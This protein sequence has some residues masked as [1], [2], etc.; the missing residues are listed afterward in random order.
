VLLTCDHASNAVPRALGGLGLGEAALSDHIGWDIG[1]AAVT[2]PLARVLDAPAI[3]SGYSRLVVDCHRD[4]GDPTS[5]PAVSDGVSIPGNRDLSPEARAARI[6]ACFAP[7]HAA[8]AARLDGV[9]AG[10]RVPAL[11]SIHSFTPVMQGV[12]RPWHIGILWDKDPRIPLPLLAARTGVSLAQGSWIFTGSATG[13]AAGALLAGVLGRWLSPKTVLMAGLVLM[14]VTG[15]VTPL[16]HSFPI[17]LVSQF[18]KGLGFGVLDVSINILMTLAFH[19]SLGESFNSLHSSYGIGA[20]V[21][22]ALLSLTLAVMHDFRPAYFTGTILSIICII[23]LACQNAPSTAAPP[24]R[25]AQPA[26][27][28]AIST[29][30]ILR[31]PLLWLMA[32]AFFF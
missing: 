12:A 3:L 21:A 9:L 7:Y 20:L 15:M 18:T 1:A 5:I 4:P 28:A 16:T 25:S 14:A 17:L 23:M 26:Q 10:G 24:A 27:T 29:R 31:Q 30:Q 11:L 8:I 13:F 6:A 22:P 19:D 2:R 32:P